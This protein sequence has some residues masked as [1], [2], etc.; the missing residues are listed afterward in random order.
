VTADLNPSTAMWAPVRRCGHQ[1]GVDGRRHH[2]VAGALAA[3]GDQ[4]RRW[5]WRRDQPGPMFRA[6]PDQWDRADSSDDHG[7][8]TRPHVHR[9][10]RRSAVLK[11]GSG[12]D[13]RGA[14]GPCH[15]RA[16]VSGQM[17]ICV[18]GAGSAEMA[19]VTPECRESS[20]T[21]PGAGPSRRQSALAGPTRAPHSVCAG[22]ARQHQLNANLSFRTT[23]S[24]EATGIGLYL[25]QHSRPERNPLRRKGGSV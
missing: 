24:F 22:T 3:A 21:C 15:Q 9:P 20:V 25:H 10:V 16:R 2:A 17:G 8:R 6:L 1:L 19:A 4:H 7:G 5:R 23:L 14:Q 11:G 18:A 12:G 13:A